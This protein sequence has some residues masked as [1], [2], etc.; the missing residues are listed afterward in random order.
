MELFFDRSTPDKLRPFAVAYVSPSIT[1]YDKPNPAYRVY[2]VDGEHPDTTYVSAPTS[3]Y[4]SHALN[5]VLEFRRM[6]SR[7]A[8]SRYATPV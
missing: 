4:P 3:T 6:F 8:A 1:P 2:Y 7:E 5:P